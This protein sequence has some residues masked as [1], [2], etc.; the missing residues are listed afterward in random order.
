MAKAIDPTDWWQL[1]RAVQEALVATPVPGAV[2]GIDGPGGRWVETVGDGLPVDA[3]L[4]LSSLTKPVLAAA[5][6]SAEQDGVLALT[7]P[8]DRWLPELAEP[9]VLRAPDATATDTVPSEHR[10]QVSDLLT[11]RLG[12]GFAYERPGNPVVQQAEQAQLG[13]GP[14]VPSAVPHTPDEW[15]AHL[16]ALPLLEQPGRWWRYGTAYS[17][18]GVLLARADGRGLPEVLR[19]RVTRP[20]GMGSTGFHAEPDRAGRLVDC[21]VWDGEGPPG[22]LDPGSGSAWSRPPTFPD[23]AGG[24]LGTVDDVLTF[25]RALLDAGA[26]MG[27]PP[28]WLSAQAVEAMTIEQVP[29]EQRTGGGNASMFLDPD[30]WG[31]GVALR[32]GDRAPARYGWAGGLGTFWY[33]YPEHDTVAVA[34]TQC[35]PPP[36]SILDAFFDGLDERLTAG[37]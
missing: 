26:G 5:T 2:L 35:V 9:R 8:V 22:V 21:L 36:M 3:L 32:S 19:E 1:R 17:V 15:L 13:W 18:L 31:Y 7:D 37:G 25:G 28:G 14:P 33:S 34:A 16:A 12:T 10:L 23:G 30:T 6:L 27:R 11:M 20:L 24:L 4:R 29:P